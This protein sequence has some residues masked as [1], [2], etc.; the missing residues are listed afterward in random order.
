MNSKG[1]WYFLMTGAIGLWAAAVG[2][3]FYFMP[4]T[5][6]SA[7]YFLMVVAGLH[8][9]EVPFVLNMLKDRDIA[10]GAIVLKTFT[11]GFT[12][13]LPFKKEILQG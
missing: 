12:W 8:A 5:G 2:T 7:W 11:F 4:E 13:W 10:K 1:F 3:G 9:S 6:I